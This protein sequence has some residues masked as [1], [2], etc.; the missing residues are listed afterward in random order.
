MTTVE[1]YGASDDL[2]EVEGDITEE[3]NPSDGVGVLA[4]SEGTVL[5]VRY[6]DA[7]LWKIT[8]TA[9]GT[10][11]CS[12]LFE[13]TDPDSGEYSDKMQ[14]MGDIEWVALAGMIARKRG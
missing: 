6:T 1:I 8:R 5:E 10:A 11:R 14:L 12:N 2:I 3:F 4:F 9:K 7:G 13:A